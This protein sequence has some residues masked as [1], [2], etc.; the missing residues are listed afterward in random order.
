MSAK[1]PIRNNKH[2]VLLVNDVRDEYIHALNKLERKLGRTLR[3]IVL[4]DEKVHKAGGH[5][6]PKD[7]P[8]EVRVCDFSSLASLQKATKD[9]FKDVLLVACQSERNQVYLHKLVPFLPYNNLPTQSS[10]EWA[11]SKSDMRELLSSYDEKA[12][13]PSSIKTNYWRN[14]RGNR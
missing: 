7:H 12:S 1:N 13:N 8:F 10:L 2:I 3:P 11:T 5:M 4:I 14:A 9:I 6:S